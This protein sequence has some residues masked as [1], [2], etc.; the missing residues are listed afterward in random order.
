MDLLEAEGIAD[1]VTGNAV[2]K[3]LSYQPLE[4]LEKDTMTKSELAARLSIPLILASCQGFTI[5]C[6]DDSEF[7][8]MRLDY[9]PKYSTI[10]EKK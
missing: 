9:L 1:E 10:W 3:L 4:K 8:P 7:S 2:K 5:G 6:R